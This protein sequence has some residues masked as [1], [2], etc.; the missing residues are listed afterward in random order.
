M[1]T[2]KTKNASQRELT[3]PFSF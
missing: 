1:P 2:R 3:K